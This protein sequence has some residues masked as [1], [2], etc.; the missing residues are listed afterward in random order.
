MYSYEGGMLED[1]GTAA[2]TEMWQ[3]TTDPSKAPDEPDIIAI[4]FK[5]GIPVKVVNDTEKI[6]KTGALDIFLYLNKLG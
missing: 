6:E 1:P 2:E 4:T 5:D 3:R